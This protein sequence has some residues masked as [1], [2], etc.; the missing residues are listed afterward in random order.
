M[1]IIISSINEPKVNARI[2]YKSFAP[3]FFLSV[4]FSVERAE[5]FDLP[6]GT[7]CHL[8]HLSLQTSVLGSHVQDCLVMTL[9]VSLA[10]KLTL[11]ND[12]DIM[13]KLF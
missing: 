10:F 8:P 7:T 5:D 3:D 12:A 13:V 4:I 1:E 6:I 9:G 2:I 11:S